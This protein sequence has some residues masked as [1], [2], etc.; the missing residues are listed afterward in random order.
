AHPKRHVTT[1]E[2]TSNPDPLA[3]LR[4]IDLN[5]ERTLVDVGFYAIMFFRSALAYVSSTSGVRVLHPDDFHALFSVTWREATAL[6]ETARE[7]FSRMWVLHPDVEYD[8][9]ARR[10]PGLLLTSKGYL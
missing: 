10:Q 9:L 8:R 5:A 4:V 3:T 7:A 2:S 1:M 6:Y